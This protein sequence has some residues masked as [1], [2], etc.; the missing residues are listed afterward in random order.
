[1]I[2]SPNMSSGPDVLEYCW[3]PDKGVRDENECLSIFVCCIGQAEHNVI[4][5]TLDHT[6]IELPKWER[7][8]TRS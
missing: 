7:D 1:M 5:C 2:R 3:S 4:T 6:L 8:I